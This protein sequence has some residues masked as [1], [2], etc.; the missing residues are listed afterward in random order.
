MDCL[1]RHACE[2]MAKDIALFRAMEVG[3][4]TAEFPISLPFRGGIY[5]QRCVDLQASYLFAV[6]LGSKDKRFEP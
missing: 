6:L 2:D 5:S 1:T 4:K 3:P